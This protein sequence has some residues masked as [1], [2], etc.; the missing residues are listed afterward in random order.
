M[1]SVLSSHAEI[2]AFREGVLGLASGHRTRPGCCRSCRIRDEVLVALVAILAVIG[3][4]LRLRERVFRV[5]TNWVFPASP[6]RGSWHPGPRSSGSGDLG[7]PV[8]DLVDG[9]SGYLRVCRCR[10]C[11]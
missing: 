3:S 10:S 7:V 5:S 6:R 8:A 9:S 4:G 1:L 2:L 11:I